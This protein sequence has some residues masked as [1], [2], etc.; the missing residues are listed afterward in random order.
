MRS[1][2]SV[3]RTVERL[4]GILLGPS[5]EFPKRGERFDLLAGDHDPVRYRDH[6]HSNE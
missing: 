4:R 3:T 2:E 5:V 1:G 6:V